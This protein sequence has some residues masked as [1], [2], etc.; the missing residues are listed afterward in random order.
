MTGKARSPV[1]PFLSSLFVTMNTHDMHEDKC[2]PEAKSANL[3]PS[4]FSFRAVHTQRDRWVYMTAGISDTYLFIT[5]QIT[6]GIKYSQY[7]QFM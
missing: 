1:I 7:I 6:C 5:F 4:F 2:Q 3:P